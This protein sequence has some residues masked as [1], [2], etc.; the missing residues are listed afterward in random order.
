M[1]G[2]AG[3][4]ET[5]STG[6][7]A[8]FFSAWAA[9]YIVEQNPSIAK[10]I[11]Q[12]SDNPSEE[13]LVSMLEKNEDLKRLMLDQT[14]GY[15][16]QPLTV[17][18]WPLLPTFSTPAK[19]DA[20][21][22]AATTALAK[23]QNPDGG[24][25]WG[26]WSKES[27]EW[28]TRGVLTTI[29]IAKSLNLIPASSNIEPMLQSAFSYVE[30]RQ[31]SPSAAKPTMSLPSSPHSCPRSSMAWQATALIRNTVS[32]DGPQLAYRRHPRQGIRCAAACRKR[33]RSRS[34]QGIRIDSRVRRCQGWHGTLLPLG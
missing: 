6:L 17:S 18:V 14:P 26:G 25:Q 4:N 7:E 2:I 24:F 23:L 20:A 19:A 9:K 29:G 10:A 34:P 32:R 16:P 31:P 8:A 33:S 15:R 13:A 27:S 3:R 5:T 30:K 1:R 21:I 28:A 12:W 11:K 22:N